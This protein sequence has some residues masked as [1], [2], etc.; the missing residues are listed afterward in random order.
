MREIRSVAPDLSVGL[1]DTN[2]IVVIVETDDGEFMAEVPNIRV[3]GTRLRELELI[4][5]EG[6]PSSSRLMTITSA[7]AELERRSTR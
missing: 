7:E 5:L 2:K 4:K 3:L 1:T 6:G